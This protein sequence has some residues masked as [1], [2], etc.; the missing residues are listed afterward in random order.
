VRVAPL[1]LAAGCAAPRPVEDPATWFDP[2]APLVVAER[3]E[4]TDVNYD[5]T[6]E[7]P[8]A[9][10]PIPA[11]DSFVSLFAEGD[12]LPACEEWETTP[13]LPAEITGIVTILPRYYYK[14]DGCDQDAEKYYGSFFLQDASG[15]IF[16]LN[17]SKV[18][19]FLAGDRVTLSVRGVANRFDLPMVTAL[20]VVDVQPHPEPIYFQAANAAFDQGDIA[21]VE[22]V[23][24]TVATE[25]DTFGAFDLTQ[26]GTGV[27]YGVS[28]DS[29]LARRGVHYAVGTRITVTGPVLY[30]YSL[31][32]IIVM[33]VG[34]VSLG[35]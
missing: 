33:Q 13:D 21:L 25:A 32:S 12:P 31:Y 22:R 1:F 14:T 17:D 15:G 23:T 28:I 7:T 8:I 24:G 9:D 16:V 6:G 10:L 20:D 27:T 4:F 34:Q 29:D 3:L 26:D 5:F 35:I 2:G 18:S 11:G 30:S 19:H